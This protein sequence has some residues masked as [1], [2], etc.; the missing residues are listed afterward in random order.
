MS[1]VLQQAKAVLE[2]VTPLKH[3]CGAV[4]GAACCPRLRS[5]GRGKR[6]VLF[7]GEAAAAGFAA[8]DT[9]EGRLLLCSGRCAREDRRWRAG[10]FRC[11]RISV[12]TAAFVRYTIRRAYRV[13][14]LVRLRER[15]PLDREFVRAVRRAGRILAADEMLRADLCGRRG[16]STNST[17]FFGWMREGRRL[18]GAGG[19]P[20]N[21]KHRKRR[22]DLR[23]SGFVPGMNGAISRLCEK[24]R[25]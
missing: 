8:V 23:S 22:K 12:R 6:H 14:P 25:A 18:R 21:K 11:F 3:D 5:A 1:G 16:K 15:V 7:P 9:P 17:D 20:K 24:G 13:C 10:C 4:C 2:R 19:Q